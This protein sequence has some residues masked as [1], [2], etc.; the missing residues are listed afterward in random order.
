MFP[1]A[2]W[3]AAPTSRH[4]QSPPSLCFC[5]TQG[6]RPCAAATPRCR[7]SG[8]PPGAA[9]IFPLL[10]RAV[11]PSQAAPTRPTATP[12][13]ANS[14]GAPAT[15]TNAPGRASDR[16]HPG[17]PPRHRHRHGRHHHCRHRH[18]RPRCDQLRACPWRD[19]Y[20]AG[21]APLPAVFPL[22]LRCGSPPGFPTLASPTWSHAVT[23]SA[24]P[25][26]AS[27]LVGTLATIQAA[28]TAS[29]ERERTASL[30][31]E[32]ER[33]LGAA[34]TTQMATMQRLLGPRRSLLWNPWRTP[35]PLTSTPT[36]SLLSTLKPLVLLTLRRFVLDDH[37][38]VDHDAPPPRSLC[39]MDIVVLS[40]LHDTITV[41]L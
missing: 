14:P 38:L 3:A 10:P 16:P 7:D 8:A 19:P 23:P 33:A 30:A 41:E 39:L 36:S 18:H 25:T 11:L 17:Q 34:L 6:R 2:P 29:R 40:W 13:Y 20:I 15:P 9:D 22:T 26:T 5:R 32:R 31:L 35:S 4:V 37:V 12:P 28:V 21:L 1:V 24:L 27:P